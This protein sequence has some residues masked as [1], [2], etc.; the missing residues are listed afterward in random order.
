MHCEPHTQHTHP[1][2]LDARIQDMKEMQR[3]GES[4]SLAEAPHHFVMMQFITR[5][6]MFCLSML[7]I[8]SGRHTS[9][10]CKHY[11][12]IPHPHPCLSWLVNAAWVSL[13]LTH[14][15]PDSPV[16]RGNTV[17]A[18]VLLTRGGRRRPERTSG[19]EGSPCPRPS[20]HRPAARLRH[21]A[22][23]T[24]QTLTNKCLGDDA[25]GVASFQRAM[26]FDVVTEH[27]NYNYNY[28]CC[29]Y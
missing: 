3:R 8:P 19:C 9:T 4:A 10:P 11:L 29:A 24:W 17:V 12:N 14:Y 20:R 15:C 6:E 28:W 16:A 13:T 25:A 18:G 27:I 26:W 7:R 2:I 22:H 1:S 23:W 21:H 5:L